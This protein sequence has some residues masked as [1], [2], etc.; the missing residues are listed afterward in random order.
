MNDSFPALTLL[1][2]D[3]AQC[4]ADI[5]IDQ[6]ICTYSD[7]SQ[8]SLHIGGVE[9]TWSMLGSKLYC[10]VTF[11]SADYFADIPVS[12]AMYGAYM[13]LFA[14]QHKLRPGKITALLV[15]PSINL[16]RFEEV[17]GYLDRVYMVSHVKRMP[18][19]PYYSRS[20]Y[21]PRANIK[22]GTVQLIGCP[23]PLTGGDSSA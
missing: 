3:Y 21:I 6:L 23:E 2:I 8:F 22:D 15:T 17:E 9:S 13:Q 7:E 16:H 10:C 5:S 14:Q 11:V 12:M 1:D 4:L 19:N 20:K 18:I